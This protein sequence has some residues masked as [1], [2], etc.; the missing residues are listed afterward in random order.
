[1][2]LISITLSGITSM[3]RHYCILS[4]NYCKIIFT[5]CFFFKWGDVAPYQISGGEI[6]V[7]GGKP[8]KGPPHDG[9]IAKT[10]PLGEKGFP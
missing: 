10:P 1:M 9:K 2:I 6:F 8:K 4:L 7:R 3:H 5:I